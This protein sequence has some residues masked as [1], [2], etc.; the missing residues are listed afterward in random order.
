MPNRR[1]SLT[2]HD[3]VALPRQRRRRRPAQPRSRLKSP[4]RETPSCGERQ[5]GGH[6]HARGRVYYPGD[7]ADGAS[8]GTGP[9]APEARGGRGPA[10]EEDEEVGVEEGDAPE[11]GHAPELR[12]ADHAERLAVHG[13]RSVTVDS[14]HQRSTVTKLLCTDHR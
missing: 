4:Q 11:D 7:H 1:N 5:R 2:E 14:I 3:V 13:G 8:A 6:T 9:R 10:A 12:R